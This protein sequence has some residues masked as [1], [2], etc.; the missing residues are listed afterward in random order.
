MFTASEG[1]IGTLPLHYTGSIVL[2][3]V[4]SAF[5]DLFA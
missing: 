2:L 4:T 5:V 3:L 1:L